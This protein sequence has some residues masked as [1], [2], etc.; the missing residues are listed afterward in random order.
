MSGVS[1]GSL[2]NELVTNDKLELQ[3]EG[4]NID[5]FIQALPLQQVRKILDVGSG[6]GSM[7]R[8]LAILGRRCRSTGWT[9]LA[10]TFVTPK[11]WPRKRG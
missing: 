7:S 1:Y 2:S 9:S 8:S 3:A 4:E 6:S 11:R 5:I 10:S